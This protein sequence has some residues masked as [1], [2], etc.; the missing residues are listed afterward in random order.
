MKALLSEAQRL[1]CEVA[2]PRRTG[3]VRVT[4][5]DGHVLNVNNRRKSGTRTLVTALRRLQEG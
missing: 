2:M 3:E 1:E 4:L 5:P